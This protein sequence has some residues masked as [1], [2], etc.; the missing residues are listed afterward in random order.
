MQSADAKEGGVDDQV[1]YIEFIKSMDRLKFDEIE[2]ERKRVLEETEETQQ[3]EANKSGGSC[4][5]FRF[6]SRKNRD[7]NEPEAP[8]ERKTSADSTRVKP[9]IRMKAFKNNRQDT[10]HSLAMCAE[11]NAE[12]SPNVTSSS[13]ASLTED[14]MRMPYVEGERNPSAPQPKQKIYS[15][16]HSEP[17]LPN[18]TK[19]TDSKKQLRL[20]TVQLPNGG[21][22]GYCTE[23]T[24]DTAVERNLRTVADPLASAGCAPADEHEAH[25][26]KASTSGGGSSG[27]G[28]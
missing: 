28:N 26:P 14:I 10:F 7:P 11:P 3:K 1:D 6:L 13:A 24:E 5:A 17:L 19:R 25:E 21:V 22:V 12:P 27:S 15:K 8:N 2:A 23:E 9:A 18:T 16:V 4:V 20:H